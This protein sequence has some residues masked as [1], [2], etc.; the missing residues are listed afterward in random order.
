MGPNPKEKHKKPKQ[1][2]KT[3]KRTKAKYMNG[4]FK[5]QAFPTKNSRLSNNI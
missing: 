2:F 3:G 1:I 5:Y 4:K